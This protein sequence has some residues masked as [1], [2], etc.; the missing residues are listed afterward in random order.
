M[1]YV[2]VASMTIKRNRVTGDRA[3]PVIAKRGRGGKS[4]RAQSVDILGPDGGV[5]ATVVYSP[6]RPL[7][8]GAVVFVECKYGV[9]VDGQSLDSACQSG[10]S[11]SCHT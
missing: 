10:R 3:P 9:L 1:Y 8:C 6:D 2:H 7:P 4:A 11:R 5:V